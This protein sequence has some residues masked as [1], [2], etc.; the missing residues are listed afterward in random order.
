MQATGDALTG[1]PAMGRHGHNTMSSREVSPSAG[2]PTPGLLSLV[3]RGAASWD[4]F[5][6]VTLRTAFPGH[7][8]LLPRV[9][10]GEGRDVRK[11][12]YQEMLKRYGCISPSDETSPRQADG[13]VPRN[14]RAL[15]VRKT[16]FKFWLCL[17]QLF[18]LGQVTDL[19]ESCLPHC[20]NTHNLWAIET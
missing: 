4:K 17:Y 19:S 2:S 15:G 8:R 7:L 20:Q 14:Q 10:G 6:L 12:S 18:D 16:G 3:V 5:Q 11:F 1:A 9:M 13:R